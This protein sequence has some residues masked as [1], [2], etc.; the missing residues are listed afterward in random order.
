MKYDPRKA[1]AKK[2][3]SKK[4]SVNSVV[5]RENIGSR[6]AS[7]KAR[8]VPKSGNSSLNGSLNQSRNNSTKKLRNRNNS[9]RNGTKTSKFDRIRKNRGKTSTKNS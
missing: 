5:K 9:S 6:N 7:L 8:N 1:L 4:P 3:K 2:P